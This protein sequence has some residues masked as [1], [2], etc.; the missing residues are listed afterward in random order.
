MGG[1]VTIAEFPTIIYITLFRLPLV[2][3][4]F[5]LAPCMNCKKAGC[6]T[7]F[8][9]GVLIPLINF[10][11]VYLLAFAQWPVARRIDFQ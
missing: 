8:G 1:A 3:L 9:A 10:V 11:L 7:W 5:L 4:L 6:W 2:R